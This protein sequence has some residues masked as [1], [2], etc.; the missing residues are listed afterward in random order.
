MMES[1][2]ELCPKDVVWLTALART[3]T[4]DGADADD[5]VQE[6]WMAARTSPPPR[7]SLNRPWL[8]TVL[9]RFHLQALRSARR[10]DQRSRSAAKHEALP[11]TAELVER[12]ELQRTLSDC[13]LSLEDPY[14]TTLMLV[15]FEEVT[16]AEIAERDG[17]SVGIVRHRI[18]RAREMM[19]AK[20]MASDGEDWSRWCAVLLP[21]ARLPLP[22]EAATAQVLASSKLVTTSA[23][24]GA[25]AMT[26]KLL[27]TVSIVPVLLTAAILF[28]RDPPALAPY[29]A[30]DVEPVS[31]VAT[32]MLVD[33]DLPKIRR[34]STPAGGAPALPP[35]AETEVTAEAA[36]IRTASSQ[37]ETPLATIEI[38]IR[39]HEGGWHAA[40]IA[41]EP[42]FASS[43]GPSWSTGR[44]E[45]GFQ[46]NSSSGQGA[47]Q[48]FGLSNPDGIFHFANVRPGVP[49][50]VA[51]VDGFFFEGD[52]VDVSPLLPG[53]DRIVEIVVTR[54]LRRF[55][56]RVLSSSGEPIAG[57]SLQICL[58]GENRVKGDTTGPD[59]RFRMQPIAVNELILAVRAKGFATAV[60]TRF[61]IPNG[62]IDIV[63]EPGRS[64]RVLVRD[65]DLREVPRAA[66]VGREDGA[67]I[68]YT[69]RGRTGDD[70]VCKLNAVPTIDLPLE[71]T[72]NGRT[73]YSTLPANEV[74]YIVEVPRLQSCSVR[75]PGPRTASSRARERVTLRPVAPEEGDALRQGLRPD[76]NV[77][78]FDR[79]FSGTYEATLER[80]EE[81]SVIWTSQPV[82]VQVE[83]AGPNEFLL[84]L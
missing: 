82:L 64:V 32:P 50:R 59:G 1:Q 37:P 31:S 55:R 42:P 23:W 11:G 73:F 76:T 4:R 77:A 21:I 67:G 5:L 33:A 80:V 28:D 57:A 44:L 48:T 3:L 16:T 78:V 68:C 20:L 71:V 83:E 38:R 26:F 7:G 24:V 18:R 30:G 84:D 25:A 13:L 35:P 10:R 36:P 62:P 47:G 56:G 40:L 15:A 79:V 72:V 39:S 63:L 2:F 45:G 17:V 75:V 60:D 34:R 8:G 6:A 12:A 9:R 65:P 29:V 54:E 43:D 14:R 27:V 69:D 58:P 74:E 61:E 51:A 49:L 41:D 19:R 53:E 81:R 46:M 52:K 22:G 70:G 66:I